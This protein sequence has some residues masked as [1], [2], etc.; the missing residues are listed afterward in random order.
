LPA[1]VVVS[2][3]IP[4]QE[5][6]FTLALGPSGARLVV[7]EYL[8]PGVGVATGR[9]IGLTIHNREYVAVAAGQVHLVAIDAAHDWRLVRLEAVWPLV[10]DLVGAVSA[11][12][13]LARLQTILHLNSLEEA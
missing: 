9:A 5:E 11:A 8:L 13:L 3:G 6:P 4:H 10:V 2:V 1:G 12:M 7:E